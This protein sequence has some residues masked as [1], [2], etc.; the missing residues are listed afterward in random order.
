[1]AKW[2]ND[3]M[4]KWLNSEL[5][6]YYSKSRKK[7]G[8]IFGLTGVQTCALPICNPKKRVT[9]PKNSLYVQESIV[10]EDNVEE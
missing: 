4:A 1:M 8:A 3:E 5:A 7:T 6:N 2:R 9:S 10:I